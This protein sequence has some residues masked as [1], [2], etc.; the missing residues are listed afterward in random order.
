MNLVL[1]F[2]DDFVDAGSRVAR[3][4]GRRRTHLVEV[5]RAAPGDDVV[6]GLAGGPVGRGRVLAVDADAATLEVTL[7]REP[8]APLPVTLV[9]ALPRPKVLSRTVAAAVSL[10]IRRIALVNAWKVERGFWT[11]PRLTDDDL[12]AAA[13]LG[14]EQA[15]DTVLPTITLHR[16]LR[17]FVEEELPALAAGSTRLVP[18]PAAPRPCPRGVDGPVTLA[19]GPEGGWIDDEVSLLAS[20]GFA[21][22][23]LGDRPLRVETVLPF[24]VG[25]VA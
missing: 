16:Y 7:D 11:S 17:P 2:P 10:G 23:S 20:A 6:V 15:K 13:I 9:L 3:L 4:S 12:R 18:H 5:H 8:P 1:L 19:I 21:P 25:R 14:L 22:V 24:L